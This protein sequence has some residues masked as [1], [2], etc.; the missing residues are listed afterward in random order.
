MIKINGIAFDVKHFPD[1][2]QLLNEFDE[3]L[4][5]DG[6]HT[7]GNTYNI[8]WLYETDNELFT[9]YCIVNHIR[10]N[11]DNPNSVSINLVMPYVPNGR[12]DRTH[13]DNEIFTL[14]YFAKFINE[15]DFNT[16]SVFDPHSNVTNAL[17]NNLKVKN[18]ILERNV[19]NVLLNMDSD[20]VGHYMA[21]A[22]YFPD[23]GA[24]KRYSNLYEINERQIFYGKK[25]RVWETG[26]IKGLEIY[27]AKGEK[28]T[29][30]DINGL[31]ILMIDDIISYGGT[32]AYSADALKSLGA[33]NICAYVS[34]TENSVL[35]K[36]RGTFL[37]RLEDNTIEKLY[38]TNSLY[39]GTHDKIELIH[40]F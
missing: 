29:F 37:K 22:L 16:V 4:L 39:S 6:M 35:D 26:E 36:E 30:D 1:G 10:N 40:E 31:D 20:D 15:L 7:F 27:N 8:T 28:A 3:D 23:E 33:N 17:L 21:T 9:L 11:H 32:L 2:T 14:K 5:K 18:Y 19:T 24:Y 38:T 13:S 12:M 25:V 34:H